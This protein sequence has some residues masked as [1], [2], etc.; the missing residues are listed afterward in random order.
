[1]S[2]RMGVEARIHAVF[3]TFHVEGQLHLSGT[4]VGWY[5]TSIIAEDSAAG[6]Y[7][8]KKKKRWENHCVL[9]QHNTT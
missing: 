6:H 1:M 5:Q 9:T 8:K 7:G 2:F 4:K 3:T